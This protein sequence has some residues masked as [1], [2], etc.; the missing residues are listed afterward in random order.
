MSD[1]KTI[2][3]LSNPSK[4]SALLIVLWVVALL[5][6]LVFTTTQFLMVDMEGQS[7]SSVLFRAEQLADRGIAI[8]GHPD[9]ENGDPLL[10]QQINESDSFRARIGSEG[11]LLNLNFLLEQEDRRIVL[12]EL[13]YQW[14]V[15]S[16]D[17]KEVVD[18]LIDW[19]D[20]DEEEQEAGAERAY[21][22]SQD[23]LRHPYNRD[24]RTLDEVPLVA[25][26]ELVEE[27]RPDWREF[28]T[29][30][31]EGPLDLSD[32]SPESISAMCQCPLEAARLVCSISG[33]TGSVAGDSR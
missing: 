23:R 26:F 10:E 17:V 13:F 32:A 8:A 16:D 31:S 9:V 1:L 29:L 3:R 6:L 30:L 12:E 33:W 24:F 18:C 7:N 22:L 21:Y 27:V 15:R 5:S 20:P 4:G 25:N 14:G 28:F 11:A 2:D 19:V